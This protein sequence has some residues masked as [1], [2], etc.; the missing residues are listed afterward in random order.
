MA[1]WTYTGAL[2][3]KIK[4]D[5][6]LCTEQTQSSRGTRTAGYELLLFC[7]RIEHSSCCQLIV[8]KNPNFELDFFAVSDVK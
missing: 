5:G 6:V 1:E 2:Q 3:A 7:S 8:E 4:A